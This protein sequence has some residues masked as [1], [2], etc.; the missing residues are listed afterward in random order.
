MDDFGQTCSNLSRCSFVHLLLLGGKS[1]C[2]TD[3]IV[4]TANSGLMSPCLY[5]AKHQ[6]HASL[7]I[8]NGNLAIAGHDVFLPLLQM[9][10]D[11]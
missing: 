2:L 8:K 3:F 5:L 10:V 1:C 4:G 11:L 7:G 6:T 9:L